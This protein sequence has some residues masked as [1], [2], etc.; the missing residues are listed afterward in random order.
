[1]MKMT[2]LKILPRASFAIA[3]FLI[4]AFSIAAVATWGALAQAQTASPANASV[5]IISPSDG[6]TVTSPIKVQFG[7]AGMG[8]APAGVEKANTGHHHLIIDAKLSGDQLKDAIPADATH[9][10][11]GAGQTETTVTLPPGTHTLQLVLGDHNHIPH[12]P[13]VMSKVVTI[14]VK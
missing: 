1:M 8:V 3:P 9:V 13:P 5:Y 7:L 11:F 4:S 2:T 10:H 12:N 6:A 14:T